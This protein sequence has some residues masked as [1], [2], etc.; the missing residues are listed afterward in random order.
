MKPPA[1][2]FRFETRRRGWELAREASHRDGAVDPVVPAHLRLADDPRERL[3]GRSG[4]GGSARDRGASG[5]GVARALGEDFAHIHSIFS[6]GCNSI[7]FGAA[8]V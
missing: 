8:P 1:K 4:G 7:T 3:A 2:V 6:N 5:G